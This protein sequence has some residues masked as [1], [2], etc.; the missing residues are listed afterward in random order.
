MQTPA[1]S[2][3]SFSLE[4]PSDQ[5]YAPI[6]QFFDL[7]LA[8]I[9]LD[10]RAIRRKRRQVYLHA[11]CFDSRVCVKLPRWVFPLNAMW[12]FEPPARML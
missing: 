6:A 5:Q 9:S 7:W 12:V 4:F 10:A 11:L 8:L 1:I 2:Q 3:L